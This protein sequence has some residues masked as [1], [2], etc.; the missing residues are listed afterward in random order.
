MYT[1]IYMKI[2][3]ASHRADEGK[4]NLFWS[5]L[6]IPLDSTAAGSKEEQTDYVKDGIAK[7][8]LP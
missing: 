8:T 1:F 7:Q 6:G 5:Q 3:S 4:G 2:L